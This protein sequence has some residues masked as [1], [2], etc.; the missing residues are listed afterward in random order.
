MRHAPAMVAHPVVPATLAAVVRIGRS[1]ALGRRNTFG[2]KSVR[3]VSSNA[4]RAIAL[5]LLS[6]A[7]RRPIKPRMVQA[8]RNPGPAGMPTGAARPDW[9]LPVGCGAAEARSLPRQSPA[10]AQ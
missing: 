10:S 6:P 4:W 9:R 2:R 3:R 7:S 5:C 1:R 8:L